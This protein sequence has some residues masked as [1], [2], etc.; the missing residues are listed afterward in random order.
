LREMVFPLENQQLYKLSQPDAFSAVSGMVNMPCVLYSDTNEPC[1]PK[2]LSRR[3][4]PR[5]L[6]DIEVDVAPLR[7]S[8]TKRHKRNAAWT[9]DDIENRDERRKEKNRRTAKVTRERKKVFAYEMREQNDE[10]W[11]QNKEL[12]VVAQKLEEALCEAREKIKELSSTKNSD[13]HVVTSSNSACTSSCTSSTSSYFEDDSMNSALLLP[14]NTQD[15]TA[16]SLTHHQYNNKEYHHLCESSSCDYNN[17]KIGERSTTNLT[18]ESLYRT[19]SLP[20]SVWNHTAQLLPPINASPLNNPQATTHFSEVAETQDNV[21][22]VPVE[23]NLVKT[24]LPE[25]TCLPFL[26][27]NM[28][29]VMSM[30]LSTSLMKDDMHQHLDLISFVMIKNSFMIKSQIISKAQTPYKRLQ[31]RTKEALRRGR[32][33]ISIISLCS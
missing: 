8:N 26:L 20:G 32:E 10:L 9:E 14:V 6:T 33:G 12:L 28:F 29:L 3:K 21:Q 1:L 30:R 11:A 17:T 23:N 2:T 27:W 16:S 5:E 25:W 15:N 13:C 4:R 7:P 31:S 18:N 24:S 19:P 22:P